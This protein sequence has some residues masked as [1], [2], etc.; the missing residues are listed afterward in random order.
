M[1]IFTLFGLVVSLLSSGTALA[2]QSR[3]PPVE[4]YKQMV[5]ATKEQGWVAFRDYA[6]KQSIYFTAL[7][8]FRCGLNAIR[9]SIN[10]SELDKSFDLVKCVPAD[11]FAL[12]PDFGPEA[13]LVDL[14]LGIAKT[15]AVQVEFSDG[16][17]SDVMVYEPCE[18]VGDR[19]CAFPVQ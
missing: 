13:I 18:G 2:A 15:I 1:R 7:V 14:D 4:T 6:G 19:A 16:S 8:S 5:A 12:P 9:Y 3:V 10:S 11:P 17:M